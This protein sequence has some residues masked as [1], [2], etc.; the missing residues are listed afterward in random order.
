ML[1]TIL[2][3]DVGSWT[4]LASVIISIAV[5]IF[6]A[7]QYRH[8][9]RKDYVE[10]LSKRMDKCELDHAECERERT[11]LTRLTMELLEDT[12]R[13]ANERVNEERR[14]GGTP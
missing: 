2:G 12:R 7:M 5:L 8:V 11:R 9:A 1:G 14:D 6:G 13:L 4:A 10:E 3:M